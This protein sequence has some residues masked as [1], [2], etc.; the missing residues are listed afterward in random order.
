MTDKIQLDALNPAPYNPRH[1]TD[2]ELAR[3]VTS[4]REHTKAIAD[5]DAAG[6]YRM[7]STITVNRQ[8][9][10]IVGG[11]QRIKALRALGQ[12]WIHEADITWVDLVPDSNEEM[13]LNIA[14]N[15]MDAAGSFVNDDLSSL[16]LNMNMDGFDLRLT[17]LSEDTLAGLLQ[18]DNKMSG[19]GDDEN[20]PDMAKPIFVTEEQ[21][22]TI[23]AAIDKVRTISGDDAITEGR[24][25]ELICGDYLGGT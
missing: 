20:K 24:C 10:R 2:E 3:L 6:G 13:A 9:D 4:I 7:A 16:L 19:L 17:A 18:G 1:I 12:D 8:G 23:D 22:E 21:R 11:H 15:S 25:I 5:W 14:L